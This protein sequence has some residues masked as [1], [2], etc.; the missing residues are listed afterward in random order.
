VGKRGSR[1]R[2]RRLH[3][4][5]TRMASGLVNWPHWRIQRHRALAGRGQ[6]GCCRRGGDPWLIA[7][8]LHL[9]GL[10][11]YIAAD[12]PTAR[13]YYMLSLAIRRE[14][15]YQEGIGILLLLL[16]VVAVR[17]ADFSQAHQLYREGVAVVRDVHG[18][19]GLRMP[20]AGFAH[21]AA[22]KAE[23]R[24]AVRF[25]SAAAAQTQS[26]RQLRSWDWPRR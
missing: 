24:R 17:L 16:G 20:L 12:Y 22:L 4:A 19:W 10:A 21:I 3:Q 11:A 9:L 6:P 26:K 15:G 8:A 5:P 14:L 18:P 13:A 1:F 25:G 2:L 23:P 7:W